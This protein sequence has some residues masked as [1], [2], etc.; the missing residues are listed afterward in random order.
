MLEFFKKH[1]RRLGIALAIYFVLAPVAYMTIGGAAARMHVHRL[2]AIL[3]AVFALAVCG[4]LDNHWRAGDWRQVFTL[5]SALGAVISAGRFF[6]DYGYAVV[7]IAIALVWNA[8]APPAE[9]IP[10]AAHKV[11]DVVNTAGAIWLT[12]SLMV[13]MFWAVLSLPDSEFGNSLFGGSI[14][15]FERFTMYIL[16][17]SG[18][19]MYS[20]AVDSL[21]K[22]IIEAPQTSIE[23]TLGLA[24]IGIA[25]AAVPRR[26]RQ[27]VRLVDTSGVAVA[28]IRTSKV[29]TPTDFRRT[30]VHEIAHLLPFATL[31]SLPPDLRVT[32]FDRVTPLDNY[33]GRVSYGDV[34]YART[35]SF[36]RWLML[37]DR[38]STVGERLVYGQVTA[39]VE[40]DNTRWTARAQNFL[41]SGFGEVFYNTPEND[42]QIAHNRVAINALRDSHDAALLEF[43]LVNRSL[44]TELVDLLEQKKELDKDHVR[45]YLQRVKFTESIQ[46]LN[47]S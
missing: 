47:F 41:A 17:M 23:V 46:P 1:R 9:A 15:I 4:R 38:A 19:R 2:P 34:D 42:A 40:G 28:V 35:E 39:G 7:G 12:F 32:A 20:G 6:K 22:A 25:I 11:F 33:L 36:R 31:P 13:E 37:V 5:R 26:G 43:L 44:M 45:P 8:G 21:V 24:I 18:I 30:C 3:V 16:A 10:P 14:R 29:R 27:V